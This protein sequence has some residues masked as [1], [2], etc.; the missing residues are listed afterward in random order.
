M[1]VKEIGLKNNKKFYRRPYII[2]FEQYNK[3]CMLKWGVVHHKDENPLNNN[4]ENLQGM[5]RSQHMKL[6]RKGKSLS[7]EHGYRIEDNRTCF[8]CG[9]KTTKISSYNRPIWYTID[10]KNKLYSC[11]NCIYI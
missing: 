1:M 7:K 2:F 8:S 11:Y 9:L 6:H 4:I 10:R 3:C 5:T